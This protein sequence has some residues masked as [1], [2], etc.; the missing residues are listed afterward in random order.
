MGIDR[1]VSKAEG[2]A[3]HE[4]SRS[5]KMGVPCLPILETWERTNPNQPLLRNGGPARPTRMQLAHGRRRLSTPNSTKSSTHSQKEP[6][7]DCRATKLQHRSNSLSAAPHPLYFPPNDAH[8]QSTRANTLRSHSATS[9]SH[10]RLDSRA[11]TNTPMETH[12]PR[13]LPASPPRARQRHVGRWQ[14][15]HHRRLH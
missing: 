15:W 7:N 14:R 11:G 13:L 12:R 3:F 5:K 1:G 4:A 6:T 8:F 2:P 10:P 9:V